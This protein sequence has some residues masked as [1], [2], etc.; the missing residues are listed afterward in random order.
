MRLVVEGV[1]DGVREVLE[2]MR[3]NLA[4]LRAQHELTNDDVGL[5]AG[6]KERQVS[7]W[8]NAPVSIYPIKGTDTLNPRT[9]N[10]AKLA[11][12]LGIFIGDFFLDPKEFAAKYAAD[13]SPLS[14]MAVRPAS[15]KLRSSSRSTVASRTGRRAAAN[16]NGVKK[17]RTK[18]AVEPKDSPFRKPRT[19]TAFATGAVTERSPERVSVAA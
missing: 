10:L 11:H 7:V 18:T 4:W 13:V 16:G 17:G 3:A 12:A 1:E 9:V 5:L 8:L 2:N 15:T 6:V 19:L 14:L